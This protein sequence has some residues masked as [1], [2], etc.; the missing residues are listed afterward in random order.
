MTTEFDIGQKVYTIYRNRV[1]CV[2][3]TRILITK[4]AVTY[5]FHD[6]DLPANEVKYKGI[7]LYK[8]KDELIK[9][10]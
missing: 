6:P 7:L 8:T 4:D 2:E 9:S 5:T 10:L 1:C 3:I